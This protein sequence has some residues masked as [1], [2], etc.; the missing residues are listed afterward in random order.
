[1]QQL[2]LS[3]LWSSTL[4]QTASG[5]NTHQCCACTSGCVHTCLDDHNLIVSDLF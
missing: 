2:R 5:Y 3:M 1:M 4:L